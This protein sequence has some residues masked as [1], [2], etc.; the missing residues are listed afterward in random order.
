MKKRPAILGSWFLAGMPVLLA[1]L[2]GCGKSLFAYTIAVAL[3]SGGEAFGWKASRPLRVGILDGEMFDETIIRRLGQIIKGMGIEFDPTNIKLFSRDMCADSSAPFPNLRFPEERQ[4]LLRN[5]MNIDVLIVDNIN[6]LFPGGD[7]R[8]T[9]FWT[10][11]E[12]FIFDCRGLGVAPVLV[13]HTTKT[14]PG[15][16][17]G[18]SKNV[19]VCEISVVLTGVDSDTEGAHFNIGFAKTRELTQDTS[20]RSARACVDV[21]TNAL[22]WKMGPYIDSDEGRDNWAG[23]AKDMRAAGS[24]IGDIAEA[25]GKSKSTVHKTVNERRA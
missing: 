21:A 5:F 12:E 1:G 15:S 23:T 3:A 6:T 9:Q 25:L 24:S 22:T 7:E 13:H 17:A 18:S 11:V 8:G 2:P 19:R 20:P 10:P 4:E 14:T 16:P